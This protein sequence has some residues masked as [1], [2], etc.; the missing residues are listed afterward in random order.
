MQ[1][2]LDPS[3]AVTLAAHWLATTPH[4]QI[5]GAV[6][7]SLRMRFPLSVSEACEAIRQAQ[8]IRGARH[9]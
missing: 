8:Q 2:D 7:P 6:I 4:E 1:T 5:G 3:E 9:A